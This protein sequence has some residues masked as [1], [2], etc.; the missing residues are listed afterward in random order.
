MGGFVYPI[1][2]GW[3]WKGGWLQQLG[4]KDFSG[5]GPIHL[6]GGV[7]GLAGAAIL[8]PRIGVFDIPTRREDKRNRVAPE[9]E[10]KMSV[11]SRNSEVDSLGTG[12]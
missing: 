1:A 7:C 8:G 10:R 6:L 5:S 11:Q 3:A 12:R 4:Y 2:S 9:T